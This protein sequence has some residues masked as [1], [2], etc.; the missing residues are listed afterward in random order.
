MTGA[1]WTFVPAG[2]CIALVAFSFALMNFAIDEV[3]NP[4]LRSQRETP[5]SAAQEQAAS[6]GRRAPRR[7]SGRTQETEMV[8]VTRDQAGA[9]R[10]TIVRR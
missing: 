1:W 3:T 7:C 5:G 4:R 9:D 8:T 2:A 10:S 6:S